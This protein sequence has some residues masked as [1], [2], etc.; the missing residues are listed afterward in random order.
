MKVNRR[1]ARYSANRDDY[2]SGCRPSRYHGD[3]LTTA[4]TADCSRNRG[5]ESYR[6]RTLRSTKV[7]AANV[8]DVPASP[9]VGDK[10]VMLGVSTVKF[11][12]LLLTPLAYTTTLPVVAPVGTVALINVALQ[13]GVAAVVPLN[14][15]L[16]EP[17]VAPKLVPVIVTGAPTAPEVGDRGP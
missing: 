3:D 12:P 16:P 1:L 14:V 7:R 2:R 15:T 11:T 9:D 5:V 8:T 6:A 13:P 10:V 17:L 4:P